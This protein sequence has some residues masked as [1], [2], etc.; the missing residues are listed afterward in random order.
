MGLEAGGAGHGYR[1]P[2]NAFATI[3]LSSSHFLSVCLI[4]M[5]VSLPACL[6][7]PPPHTQSS[8]AGSTFISPF[9]PC[10]YGQ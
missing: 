5:S 8:Q 3:L 1:L 2:S 7:L 6:S 10:L 9:F 4:F